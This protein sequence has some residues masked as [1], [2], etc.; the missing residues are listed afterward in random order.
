MPRKVFLM[1]RNCL[2]GVPPCRLLLYVYLHSSLIKRTGSVASYLSLLQQI[3]PK[4]EAFAF[5]PP[6]CS[7]TRFSLMMDSLL[8]NCHLNREDCIYIDT[9]NMLQVTFTDVTYSYPSRPKIL[10][11]SGL[12]LTIEP[13]RV[14]ALVGLS[15]SGKWDRSPHSLSLT[16]ILR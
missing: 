13:G 4:S 7:V 8:R 12:N 10:A 11:L 9:A 2:K 15:G 16:L 3:L 6:S 1:D 14:L 5:N